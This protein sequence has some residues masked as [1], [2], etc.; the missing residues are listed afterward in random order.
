[1]LYA[2][3]LMFCSSSLARRCCSLQPFSFTGFLT[4]YFIA[5][6]YHSLWLYGLCSPLVLARHRGCRCLCSAAGNGPSSTSS[7]S[8][9]LPPA[10]QES[11]GCPFVQGPAGA[12][13][14]ERGISA[15]H[16]LC[17]L[18]GMFFSPVSLS[19]LQRRC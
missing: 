8:S 1:M 6:H 18:N 3:L 19:V 14:W 10:L 4:G 9:L 11:L 17:D 7:I 12:R 15:P 16:G 2:N 13:G 5:Y